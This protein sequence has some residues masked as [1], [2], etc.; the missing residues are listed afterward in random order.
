MSISAKFR[1]AVDNMLAIVENEEEFHFADGTGDGFGGNFTAAKVQAED[2]RH[3]GCRQPRV[4][5][6]GEFDQSH[7]VTKAGR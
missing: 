6:R 3:R 1:H 7:A 2:A 5:Q 4:R